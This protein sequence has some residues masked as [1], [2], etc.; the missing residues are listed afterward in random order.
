M[1]VDT[2]KKET[3]GK[4]ANVGREC[5]PQCEPLEVDTH[6]FPDKELGKAIAY[7]VYGIDIN[8]AWVSVAVSR[9]TAEFSVDSSRVAIVDRTEVQHGL[10]RGSNG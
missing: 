10:F 7:C 3:L 5:R 1:S 4:K 8:E 6:D 9:D 2:K